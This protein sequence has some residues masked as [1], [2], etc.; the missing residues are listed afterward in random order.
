M[1]QLQTYQDLAD[2]KG[3]LKQRT[4]QKGL[5]IPLEE[6]RRS[7]AQMEESVEFTTIIK[8]S[9]IYWREVGRIFLIE[10]H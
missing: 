7:T 2:T 1:V 3:N 10:S 8:M 4:N 6:V 9:S 5:L